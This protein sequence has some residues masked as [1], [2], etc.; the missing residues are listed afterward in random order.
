[1]GV[2]VG[3]RSKRCGAAELVTSWKA[4]GSRRVSGG[5]DDV[6]S[7]VR[8]PLPTLPQVQELNLDVNLQYSY[9]CSGR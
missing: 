9:S 1:M 3:V 7:H 5:I 4:G 8:S 2:V 6:S